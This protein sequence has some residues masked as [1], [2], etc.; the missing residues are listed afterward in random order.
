VRGFK[1]NNGTFG[2]WRVQGKIGG[3]TGCASLLC[4]PSTHAQFFSRSFPDTTRGVLNEGGLFGERA[5]WHL[6]GFDTSSWVERDLSAGLPDAGAGVGFFVTTFPL[7]I[8][9]G[10]DVMMSFTF[11][12]SNQPYRAFLFVNG[13]MMGKRV[14]N[15]GCA[16]STNLR[17]RTGT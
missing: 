15:L 14:A 6:P 2:I 1:L 8:P 11:D 5:G 13:W 9:T 10:F 12:E 7:N 17:T 16:I 4:P 3:Y